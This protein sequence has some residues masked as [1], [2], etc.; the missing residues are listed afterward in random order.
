[1]LKYKKII[2]VICERCGEAFYFRSIASA[3]DKFIE[4]HNKQF[5]HKD[6]LYMYE[7]HD[8]RILK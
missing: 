7:K 4:K 8:I 6:C 1:M 5:C 2:E 3:T